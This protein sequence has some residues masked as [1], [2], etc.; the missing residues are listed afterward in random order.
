MKRD[1]FIQ[2]RKINMQ[3]ESL[4][5]SLTELEQKNAKVG[6]PHRIFIELD[7][8]IIPVEQFKNDLYYILRKKIC[9]Q[10]QLLKEEFQKI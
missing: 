9:D 10:I 4:H 1:D 3:I 8:V 5:N 7:K 6:E 2:A